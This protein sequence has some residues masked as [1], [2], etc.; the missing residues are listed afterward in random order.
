MP[1]HHPQTTFHRKIIYNFVWIYLSRSSRP[2]VYCCK[3]RVLRNIAKLTGK[4]L[5]QTEP[6]LKV[7][8]L[9]TVMLLK[10]KLWYRCFSMDFLKFLR[11]TPFFTQLQNTS[12]G[13]ICMGQHCL[14]TKEI[15]C[16]M[17]VYGYGTMFMRKITYTILSRTCWNNTA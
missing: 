15:T 16:G 8:G 4:N 9:N 10:E 1:V 12:C 3:K 5:C 14:S 2:Q 6:F 13:C 11:R 7:A 17:L